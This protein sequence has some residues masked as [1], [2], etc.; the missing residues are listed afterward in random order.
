MC[1]VIGYQSDHPRAAHLQTLRRLFLESKI[2]GL[3]AFGFAATW[4][5]QND[6]WM[7]VKDLDLRTVLAKLRAIPLGDWPLSV[8]GH[9]RYSTSGDYRD[10]LNNQPITLDGMAFAFNGVLD[11]REKHQ[12]ET[13][14]GRTYTTGNDGEIFMRHVLDGG[15]PVEFAC[16]TGSLAACYLYHG[17]AYALRNNYRPLWYATGSGTT[18][19]ASTVDILRR[20][21][22]R[23]PALEL[24]ANRIFTLRELRQRPVSAEVS[25]QAGRVLPVALPRYRTSVRYGARR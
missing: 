9:C 18:W 11:M 17:E 13:A 21:V 6:R 7:V 16:R 5:G 1:G 22:G 24:P 25:Q 14:Y 2:R 8:I 20:A 19:V 4:R 3:H 12:Y 10:P 23:T 15:D